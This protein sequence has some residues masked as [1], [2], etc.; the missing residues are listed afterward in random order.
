MSRDFVWECWDWTSGVE[1]SL[2]PRYLRCT[3]REARRGWLLDLT[4]QRAT[5]VLFVTLSAAAVA[6]TPRILSGKTPTVRSQHRDIIIRERHGSQVTS[7]NWSGYAVTGAKDSVTDV[8]GSWVVPSVNCETTPNAY[9]AFWVGIDGY[10]SNTVEQIGTESD[11]AGGQA[12]NYAWFEFYPH[13]SYTIESVTIKPGDEI[14]AQVKYA[15][16][17]FTVSITVN[18]AASPQFS[19]STKLSQADRSSAEWIVE[20]PYSGGVLPLADFNTAS[21]GVDNTGVSNTCDAAIGNATD[22]IGSFAAAD[23]FAI[24]MTAENGAIKAQP[25]TLSTDKSSFNDMWNS[26]GP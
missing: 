22:P 6:G 20:A 21:F 17:R 19:T 5:F 13:F 8:T 12:T 2:C 15:G 11:C 9:A 24:T 3:I 23:V 10:S 16:G 4:L 26:Q 25:S 1:I 14:S 7:S 18:R